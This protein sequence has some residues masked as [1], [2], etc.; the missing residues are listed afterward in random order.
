MAGPSLLVARLA[1]L[2]GAQRRL[3]LPGFFALIL[4]AA[5]VRT[6]GYGR[7]RRLLERFGSPGAGAGSGGGRE[8][9]ASIARLIDGIARHGPY[10]ATCLPRSLTLWW[11][12]RRRGI[13]CEMRFGARRLDDG[14]LAHCWVEMDGVPLND[15]QQ[16]TERYPPF[17]S[18]SGQPSR[19]ER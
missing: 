13:S 10:Q 18:V 9:A 15:D 12:L 7:T 17:S 3:L 2:T 6:I 11:F 8:R 19:R 4:I 14:I 1:R 5:L 16:V